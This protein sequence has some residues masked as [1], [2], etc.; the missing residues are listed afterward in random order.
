MKKIN[1]ISDPLLTASILSIIFL[2]F[3]ILFENSYSVF[4]VDLL[5]FISCYLIIN[6]KF[7][8]IRN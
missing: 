7:K 6:K 3:R 8:D 5:V 1:L 4:G 2:Q